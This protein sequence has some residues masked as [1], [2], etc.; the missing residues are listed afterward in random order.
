MS[1][2]GWLILAVWVAAA[3]AAWALV[4]VSSRPKNEN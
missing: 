2:T 4:A 3:Y 1:G